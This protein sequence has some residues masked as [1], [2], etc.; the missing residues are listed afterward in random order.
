MLEVKVQEEATV[1][2]LLPITPL[3]QMIPN[4]IVPPPA[5]KP[6]QTSLVRNKSRV[7][8]STSA[9]MRTPGHGQL[10]SPKSACGDAVSPRKRQ[11]STSI[12]DMAAFPSAPKAPSH[13]LLSPI[14]LTPNYPAYRPDSSPLDS[15]FELYGFLST[16]MSCSPTKGTHAS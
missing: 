15:D 10:S 14:R 9:N 4:P 1:Q 5:P 16:P 2:G 8:S 6:R 13:P 11:T 12:L 3:D 7:L